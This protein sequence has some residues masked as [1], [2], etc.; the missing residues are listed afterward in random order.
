MLGGRII[1]WVQD[2][3]ING[4]P[5]WSVFGA[6]QRDIFF[7]NYEGLIDTSFSMTPYNPENIDDVLYIK[8]LILEIKSASLLVDQKMKPEL[9]KLHANYPNP[10]NPITSIAYD[11]S[12]TTF[13]NISIFDMTGRKIRTLI[14]RSQEEGYKSVLWNGA[15]DRGETVSAGL[16][17]YTITIKNKRQTRK[18]LLLK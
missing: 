13:V 6:N 14:K 10:F 12:K 1:P 11:L 4:H 16:Y 9:F 5:I 3:S 7:L 8:N 18:M 15:N 17:L 2:D